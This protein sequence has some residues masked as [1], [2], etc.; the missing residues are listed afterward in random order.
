VSSSGITLYKYRAYSAR[1]LE[2]LI[3]R[4]LYFASPPSLNDPYDCRINIRE[5]LSGAI[6]RANESGNQKL[7]QKLERLR[8][9]EHVYQ[10]MDADLA[11]LGVL[12]LAKSA[13]S[14]LMWSHY[15]E[16]HTGFCAG[17]QLSEKFTTHIN[18][19]QIVG[20][21]DVSYTES[22]P[23]IDYFE[24]IVANDKPPEWEEF[25]LS[26]LSMGMVAKA[27][28]WQYEQ[29]VR[30]LRKRPGSVAFMAAEL[31]EIVFGLAMSQHSRETLRKILSGAEWQHIR[32]R[33][34]VRLNGFMLLLRDAT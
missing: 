6:Q 3:R 20:A 25:W 8:K 26:L 22:N 14:I 28:P 1:A 23:F 4:E 24:E 18:D 17:F 29:E 11:E 31:T 30:V 5:S 33:E 10:K 2:M 32:F 27:K 13:D 34:V 7:Q 19:E 12:S 21:I 16:N 15:A 9:I